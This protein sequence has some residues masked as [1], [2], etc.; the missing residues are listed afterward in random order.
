MSIKFNFHTDQPWSRM[1][2]AY[3]SMRQLEGKDVDNFTGGL[4]C[5]IH[6]KVPEIVTKLYPTF[7]EVELKETANYDAQ[8]RVMTV[9]NTTETT[10]CTYIYTVSPGGGTVVTGSV[11]IPCYLVLPP[12]KPIVKPIIKKVFL[13]ERMEEERVAASVVDA[14]T[15]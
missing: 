6:R 9:K 10:S 2:R 13:E 3:L 14:T 4:S 8:T 1:V 15:I 12:L 5:T 11:V 7:R